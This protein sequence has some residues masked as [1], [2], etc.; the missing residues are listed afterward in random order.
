MLWVKAKY[1][2]GR[3]LKGDRVD[4]NEDK[5]RA[6]LLAEIFERATEEM[7]GKF[8]GPWVFWLYQNNRGVRFFA[9]PDR[10]ARTV[11]PRILDQVKQGSVIVSDEWAAYRRIFELGYIHFTVCNKRNYV[12]PETGFHTNAI[13]RFWCDS[14]SYFEKVHGAGPLLQAHL[15]EFSWQKGNTH[16][17]C[18]LLAVFW[19]DFC[20]SFQIDYI[21]Q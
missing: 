19:N 1:G 7:Y 6:E 14:K 5:S 21:Y 11:L 9:A 15:D 3:R 2:R 4:E 12:D 8:M 20:E 18:G 16:E 17:P 13:E 10:K